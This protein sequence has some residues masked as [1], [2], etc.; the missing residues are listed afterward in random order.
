MGKLFKDLKVVMKQVCK[1]ED[2]D[3]KQFAKDFADRVGMDVEKPEAT[4]NLFEQL[5]RCLNYMHCNMREL[6]MCIDQDSDYEIMLE[7]SDEI[8]ANI[9]EMDV[10]FKQLRSNLKLKCKPTTPED[11]IALKEFTE[12]K[13][14]EKIAACIKE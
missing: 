13:K 3:E 2:D 6:C 14:A 1:P 12:R 5:Q 4:G 8:N 10:L 7:K 11:K 9:G